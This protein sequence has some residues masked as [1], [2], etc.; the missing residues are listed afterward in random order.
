MGPYRIGI[1]LFGG[2]ARQ[3]QHIRIGNDGEIA[4]RIEM[5]SDVLTIS[6]AS[7]IEI[8]RVVDADV[9]ITDQKWCPEIA[10]HQA[11]VVSGHTPHCGG[12]R[13]AK[14]R[15]IELKTD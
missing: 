13:I 10:M 15:V 9:P 3:H 11:S 7:T 1:F 2:E 8:L 12:R 4:I 14:I 6:C 5:H